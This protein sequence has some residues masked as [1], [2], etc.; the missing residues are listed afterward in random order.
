MAS[1]QGGSQVRRKIAKKVARRKRRELKRLDKARAQRF[2]RGLDSTPVLAANGIRYELSQKVQAIAHGGIGMMF[3]PAQNVG[4]VDAIDNRLR[5]LKVHAPYQDS[6]HVMANVLNM[7]CG[8][9]RLENLE[10]LRNDEALL[11][12][13]GADSIPDPTSAGDDCRR[14]NECAIDALTSAIHTARLNVW[15]RQSPEFFSEAVIDV[16]GVIVGTTGECREGMDMPF[17]GVRGCHPLLVSFCNPREVLVIV[18]RP[19]NVH[20]AETA[21]GKLDQAIALCSVAGFRQIRMRGDCKFSQTEH[22]DRWDA[23]GVKFTFGC[24]GRAVLKGIAEDSRASAWKPLKRTKREIQTVERAKPQNVKREIICRCGYLHV[25]PGHE[26]VAESE[27]KPTA[28]DSAY[29]M[30]VVRKTIT[31]ERGDSVLFDE[32]RYL[33]CISNDPP[34]VAPEQVVSHCSKRCDQENLIAQLKSGVRSLCAPS[35]NLLS[36]GASVLMTSLAW[37]LKSWA[38]LLLPIA[39]GQKAKHEAERTQM[40]TMEFR[41]FPDQMIHLPCQIIR[42]ARK[43]IYRMLNWRDLTP[44]FIRL[45]DSLQI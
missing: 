15:S 5:L 42:H 4:L 6:D 3:K 31:T 26:D 23:L 40:L 17:K 20:S 7:L 29:R 1:P 11:N 44:A 22:P 10:L 45:C 18:N 24:E 43:V 21:A 19:G 25:E 39:P 28:C 35:D 8:G 13:V 30:I 12:A 27:Y 32:I 37:T 9:S 16:D 2:V 38:A 14:F 33:F 34:S 36:N 41:T